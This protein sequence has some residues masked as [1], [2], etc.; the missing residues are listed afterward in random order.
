[1]SQQSQTAAETYK[2]LLKTDDW[3]AF[4]DHVK[5]LYGNVCQACRLHSAATNVHHHFYEPGKLPW[6][7]GLG[8]VTVLCPNCHRQMHNHLQNFRRYVFPKL[9]P[10]EFQIL[11]GA[12]LVGLE[13]N[14]ALELTHAIAS[15][16]ASKSSVQRFAYD[17][18]T[19]LKEEA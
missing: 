19:F 1:M 17:A 12:L 3:K 5:G 4:S 14:G 10:R 13:N 16:C 11:N 6:E 2:L 9:K 18:K 8:D 15:M 7:Y